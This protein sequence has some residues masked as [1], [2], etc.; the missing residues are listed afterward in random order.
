MQAENP[1]AIP[2]FAHRTRIKVRWNELDANGHVNNM[3]YHSYFDQARIEAFADAGVDR[4][5]MLELGIGPVIYRS[6]IDYRKE[7][8]H[9]DYAL[10]STWFVEGERARGV[11]MQ[12]LESERDERLVATARF[13]GFFMDLRRGRP[14]PMPDEIRNSLTAGVASPQPGGSSRNDP[15]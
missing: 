3:Y 1:F 6:E 10:L 13:N 5:R 9:P 7:L 11:V 4:T 2:D 14:V 15:C 8:K 12:T